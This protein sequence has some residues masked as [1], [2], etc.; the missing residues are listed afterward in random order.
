MRMALLQFKELPENFLFIANGYS[1]YPLAAQQ[2]FREF[3]ETFQFNITQVIGLTN[4]N[5]VSKK[6]RPYKQMIERLNLTLL[7]AYQWF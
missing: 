5:A 4:D 6:F 2:F 3:C 7:P 1:A